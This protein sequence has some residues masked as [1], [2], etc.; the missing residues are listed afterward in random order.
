MYVTSQ[1]CSFCWQFDQDYYPGRR[2]R[3]KDYKDDMVYLQFLFL[4][5]HLYTQDRWVPIK[6]NDWYW[7]RHHIKVGMHVFVEV[8]VSTSY[9]ACADIGNLEGH[10]FLEKGLQSEWKINHCYQIILMWT[11]HV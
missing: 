4:N 11:R 2:K 1:L 3:G 10:P 6:G 8:L 5:S 7:I 9:F